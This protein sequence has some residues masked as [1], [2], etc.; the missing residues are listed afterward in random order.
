MNKPAATGK[1]VI[2]VNKRARFE[3]HIEERLEAVGYDRTH[4]Y[5]K[6]RWIVGTCQTFTVA[7]GFPR[8]TPPLNS[9]VHNVTYAIDLAAC[10]PFVT[11][12]EPEILAGGA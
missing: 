9:G 5:E 1:K 2:A 6:R 4:D 8:I 10:A 3:Y 7:D 11:E 12:F